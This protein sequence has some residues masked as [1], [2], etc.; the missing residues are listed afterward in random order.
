MLRVFLNEHRVGL[1]QQRDRIYHDLNAK[2]WK[3][4][5]DPELNIQIVPRG[6]KLLVEQLT[7]AKDEVV[8]N[9]PC[10]SA[11]TTVYGIPCYHELRSRQRLGLKITKDDFHQYWHFQ[12]AFNGRPLRLPSPVWS[13]IKF[14]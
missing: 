14:A 1:A 2:R 6:M 8:H 7:F 11:F 9:K 5:L 12:C 10:S 3:D 13:T 4:L